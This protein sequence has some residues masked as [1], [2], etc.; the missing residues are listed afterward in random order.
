MSLSL[1]DL[2]GEFREGYLRTEEVLSGMDTYISKLERRIVALEGQMAA[3]TAA[4]YEDGP[5]AVLP[6]KIFVG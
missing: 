5:P 6:P 1:D 3:L 4:L 2:K